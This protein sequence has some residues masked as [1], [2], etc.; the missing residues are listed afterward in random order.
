MNQKLFS[1]RLFWQGMK[2]LKIVGFIGLAVTLTFNIIQL[3]VSGN[4]IANREINGETLTE[5]YSAVQ[6]AP[7]SMLIPF[8]F[9]PVMT[10]L[11]FHFLNSRKQS[12]F[13]HAIPIRRVCLYTSLLAS[14]MAWTLVILI[15]NLAVTFILLAI[16]SKY[17]TVNT[18]ALFLYTACLFAGSLFVAAS[19]TIA[20]SVTGT[21]FT[22][23]ILT[24]IIIFLP[25]LLLFMITASVASAVPFLVDTELFPLL[26]H[27][28]NVIF[29]SILSA[30]SMENQIF[31]PMMQ[32]SSLIY[33]LVLGLIYCVIGGWLF[34]RRK[35]ECAGFSATSN[36]V[37]SLIRCGFTLVI[38]LIPIY[39]IFEQMTLY[40][41]QDISGI[42]ISY[43]LALLAYI[44]LELIAN[45]SFRSLLKS[46]PNLLIIAV[47]NVVIIF[48]M[49]ALHNSTYRYHLTADEIDYATIEWDNY[50]DRFYLKNKLSRA[51]IKDKAALS[52]LSEA[53]DSA[54]DAYEKQRDNTLDYNEYYYRSFSDCE[55]LTIAFYSDGHKTV[56]RLPVGNALKTQL[57]N[58]YYAD[59][60]FLHDCLNLPDFGTNNTK[61][62]IQNS[63]TSSDLNFSKSEKEEIYKVLQKEFQTLSF[64]N[65]FR[66]MTTYDD[67][68]DIL[69]DFDSGYQYPATFSLVMTTE[70]GLNS[71]VEYFPISNETFPQTY[72]LLLKY[73]LNEHPVSESPEELIQYLE[74]N[75]QS[76]N[77]LTLD[78][79]FAVLQ[80]IGVKSPVTGSA[81]N[82][83]SSETK[84][85]ISNLIAILETL[86]QNTGTEPLLLQITIQNWDEMDSEREY[87]FY[88][89][90]KQLNA[91]SDFVTKV[92]DFD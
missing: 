64:E 55:F 10:L 24:G 74:S 5:V 36:K 92:N 6:S 35:S 73:Y 82:S 80:D 4:D 86:T 78:I 33:T 12:D 50:S 57:R 42:V 58:V 39:M 81:F 91:F 16:Y 11:L 67:F 53:W 69:S 54:I 90:E 30:F 41:M 17:I 14:I 44:I 7:F 26:S 21:I 9:I 31:S 25:R 28:Y 87:L 15:S 3:V 27:E 23:I 56:R 72:A 47:I 40:Q 84:E 49:S 61:V 2:Q 8:L 76:E 43:I 46:W 70:I 60:D 71:Y 68:T 13:Y 63:F 32:V 34:C 45:R 62:E 19:I 79:Q 29:G 48:S 65:I 1:P 18:A 51:E 59:S 20:M 88:V 22:N 38:C 66:Y 52:G 85:E 37:M 75:I 89:T 83:C 77:D